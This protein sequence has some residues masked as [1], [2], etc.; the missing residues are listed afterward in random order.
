MNELT[1]VFSHADLALQEELLAAAHGETPPLCR[2]IQ[3]EAAPKPLRQALAEVFG[4]LGGGLG[5]RK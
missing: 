3:A 2:R 5:I 1:M 4:E